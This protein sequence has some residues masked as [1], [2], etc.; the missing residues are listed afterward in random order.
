MIT[1]VKLQKDGYLVN[2]SM[3]VPL[4]EGNRH[5]RGVQEWIAAGN[6]PD[7]EFTQDELDQLADDET[8]A[9]VDNELLQIDKESIEEMRAWILNQ[10]GNNSQLQALEARANVQ[11]ARRPI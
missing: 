8:N 10:P 5:Y 11:R 1:S 4:S 2:G 3:S 6:T 7:P 9:S